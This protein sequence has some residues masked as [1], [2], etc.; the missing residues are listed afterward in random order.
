MVVVIKESYLIIIFM[1]MVFMNGLMGENILDIGK[2][3]K[4]MEEES[5]LGLMV[6]NMMV[7]IVRIENMAM[8]NFNGLMEE[9]IEGNG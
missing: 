3:I 4:C 2:I 7:N 1:V 6:E 9:N 5:L 8:E